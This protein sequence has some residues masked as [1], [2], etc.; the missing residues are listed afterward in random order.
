M[1]HQIHHCLLL[2]CNDNH[3]VLYAS[4]MGVIT[5]GAQVPCAPKVLFIAT[6][7]GIPIRPSVN[8]LSGRQTCIP[9]AM[10][11]P[12]LLANLS[13][14]LIIIVTSACGAGS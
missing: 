13:R 6:Y 7:H 5:F 8:N 2:P 10:R 12:S 4:L 1:Y 9:L 11:H 14:H 3:Q